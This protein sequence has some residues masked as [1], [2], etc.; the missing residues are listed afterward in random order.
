MKRLTSLLCLA[1]VLLVAQPAGAQHMSLGLGGGTDG[2]GAELG[3][4]LGGHVHLR[5]GFGMATGLVDITLKN[6]SVPEHPGLP[7][8][9]QV[10]VP[11]NVRMGTRTGRLLFNIHPGR[12]S[13]YFALGA[14]VGSPC[15]F[16][17]TFSELPD[18]YNT[19]GF[20]VDGYLVKASRGELEASVEASGL[21][22]QG[23]AV[24]PYAGIGFGR[25]VCNRKNKEVSF[26][27]DL[28][29][30]YQGKPGLWADGTSIS[31]RTKHVQL[32]D[33]VLGEF[34]GK[35][36]EYTRY[37]AFWPSLNFHVHIQLF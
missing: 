7:T 14:Y 31:G 2:V 35:I 9:N 33:E 10:K 36:N 8:G 1:V 12:G 20:D 4:A 13:F 5:A 34:A 11:L 16:R 15:L 17:G 37:M 30:Q 24:K 26:C 6:F 27:L 18:D 32:S 21:G 23:F 22:P 29:V 19:A 28:G 3:V 25:A